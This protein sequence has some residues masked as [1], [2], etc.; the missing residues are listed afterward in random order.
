M[1]IFNKS[2]KERLEKFKS[3]RE[4]HFKYKRFNMNKERPSKTRSFGKICANIMQ[5]ILSV[6]MRFIFKNILYGEK[7]SSMP[8]IKNLLLLEPATVL[9]MKIRTKKVI[10]LIELNELLKDFVD[11][12]F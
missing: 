10:F 3:V 2:I 8:P 9:A 12:S 6:L 4:N 5:R 7:G 11:F 1:K